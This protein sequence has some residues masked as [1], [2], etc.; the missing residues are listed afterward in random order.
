MGSADI[1]LADGSTDWNSVVINSIELWNEQMDGTQFT[2]TTAAPGTAAS[3]GD[4]VNSMQFSSTV[5]G[6]DYG[7]NVLAVTLSD[8]TGNRTTETDI[9]YNTANRFNSYR[10]TYAIFNGISYFDLHR[11]TLHELGHVLGLDHPDEHGQTVSAIMNSRVSE[12]YNLQA[13]D[14][15]GAV[16]LYGAP[17]NAP[18]PTGNAQILQISTR[19]SVGTGDNVMIGGFIIAGGTTKKVIVRA[20]GPSLGSTGVSGALANPLLTLYDGGGNVLATNDDWRSTQ[21][22][23]ISDTGLAPTNNLE[24]AIVTDLPPSNYTAIV[25]GSAGGSGV[26]LVEVYDLEPESGKL[27]NISTRAFV[28]S[29]DNVTIGGFIVQGPQSEKN[30]IRA[31][32]PSLGTAGLQGA[33]ANPSLELYNSQGQLLQSNDDFNSN[34]DAGVIRGFGL[35]LVNGFESG[36]YF[37]SAPGNF[38]AIMRGV[39]GATGIGLIEVYGVE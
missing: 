5:Y 12:I 38:T 11:I 19:S 24:S 31:V 16:A 1:V 17:P 20:I 35:G 23:E 8:F 2:W 13:D 9:L 18:S 25:S 27:A 30:I 28:G 36:I 34:R 29:G 6:D 22:Q 7:A 33:L 14:V 4:G 10:G 37:E 26:A 39:N 3:F 32:G 21:E 15:A